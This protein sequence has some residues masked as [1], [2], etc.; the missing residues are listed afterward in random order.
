MTKGKKQMVGTQRCRI[1]FGLA[2]GESERTIAKEIGVSLSTVSRE[3]RKHTYESFKGCYG[4]ANQC[5]HRQDCKLTGVCG[6]CPA[7]GA[8]CVRCSYRNCS[9]FCDRVEYIDCSQRLL[10]TAKVCNGCPDEK[11]CHKRKLFYVASRA[12]DDY[13]RVLK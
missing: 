1:E 13:R 4:R 11:R 2:A 5:V 9:R 6:D 12:Q 7:K 3:I 8:P 10:R